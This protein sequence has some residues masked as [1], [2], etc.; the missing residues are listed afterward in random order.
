M[1]HDAHDVPTACFNQ[2][3]KLWSAVVRTV[4]Q[5]VG[6]ADASL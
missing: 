3:S 5:F 2:D 1:L 6:V 4:A